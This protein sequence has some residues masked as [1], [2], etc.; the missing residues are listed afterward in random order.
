MVVELT[1]QDSRGNLHVEGPVEVF[2]EDDQQVGFHDG[3]GKFYVPR[4]EIV[5]PKR[6]QNSKDV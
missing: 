1:W 6:L 3:F 4:H 2:Y 5:K